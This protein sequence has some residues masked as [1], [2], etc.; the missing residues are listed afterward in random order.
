MGKQYKM[1]EMNAYMDPLYDR[2]EGYYTEIVGAI[3]QQGQRQQQRQQA[4]KQKKK[5]KGAEAPPSF[6]QQ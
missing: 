4:P 5:A 2:A 1:E 6:P 3:P